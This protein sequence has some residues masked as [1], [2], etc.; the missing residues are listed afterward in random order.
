MSISWEVGNRTIAG[1]NFPF[2]VVPKEEIFQM[3]NNA[4]SNNTEK[5]TKLEMKVCRGR[6]CFNIQFTNMSSALTA[7]SILVANL[8]L[9]M[10]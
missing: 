7:F 6:E 8:A 5:A 9:L 3:Q 4:I 1:L 2:A 10:L